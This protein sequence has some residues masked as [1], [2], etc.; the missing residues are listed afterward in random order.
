[1]LGIPRGQFD[2]KVCVRPV[3]Y[4][5]V[6]G[7]VTIYCPKTDGIIDAQWFPGI[8]HLC[9]LDSRQTSFVAIVTYFLWDS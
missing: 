2:T 7:N 9:M 5:K 4:R 6:S 1:M 3:V 8:F